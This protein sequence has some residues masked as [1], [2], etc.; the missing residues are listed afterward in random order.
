MKTLETRVNSSIEMMDIE[1][2]TTEQ[3]TTT[4][5]NER[6]MAMKKSTI[7]TSIVDPMIKL[8]KKCSQAHSETLEMR[9]IR[10]EEE[11]E[12]EI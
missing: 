3:M 1:E 10:Q 2:T 8:A 7:V 11:D 12:P 4:R 6:V 9:R 5:R